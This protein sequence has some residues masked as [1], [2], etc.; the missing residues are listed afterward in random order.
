MNKPIMMW[1]NVAPSV[2]EHHALDLPDLP[3]L[4]D[5]DH[6]KTFMYINISLPTYHTKSTG[7]NHYH[8][9]PPP[10]RTYALSKIYYLNHRRIS[11]L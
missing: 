2:Q 10:P 8:L 6:C 9:P 3:D 7:D 11:A 1:T 5:S 4:P